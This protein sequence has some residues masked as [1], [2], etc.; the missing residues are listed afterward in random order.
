M[1]RLD[2][3][4]LQNMYPEMTEKFSD[5]MHH[6]VHTLPLN[7][8]EERGRIMVKKRFSV[9]FVFILI[10][11]TSSL[12][13]LACSHGYVIQYL[14]G[15]NVESEEALKMETQIQ[16]IDYIYHSDTTMCTVKDAYFDGETLAIG[17]GFKTDHHLYLVGDEIKVND[18]WVDYV[19]YSASIEEMWV[20]NIPPNKEIGADEELKDLFIK[21]V[22][23]AKYGEDLDFEHS[24]NQ[25]IYEDCF[26]PE[27]VMEIGYYVSK[28]RDIT[29]F[30][31]LLFLTKET[32]IVPEK[33]KRVFEVLGIENIKR[34]DKETDFFN[35][36]VLRTINELEI[37]P[38]MPV[39]TT[40][41]EFLNNLAIIIQNYNPQYS[42]NELMAALEKIEGEKDEN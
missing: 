10:V 14:F 41:D 40:Y 15:E 11:M 21:S 6:M 3:N 24:D 35:Y 42:K 28:V 36:Y 13:A 39:A 2:Q 1:I 33:A 27:W 38:N 8:D 4:K 7:R 25:N 18:D 23:K 12:V 32:E 31:F 22:L 19:E 29:N 9:A 34:F 20:G 5:R 16:P 17:L 26:Y 30:N 37:D